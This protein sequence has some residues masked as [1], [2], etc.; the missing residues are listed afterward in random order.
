MYTDGSARGN[1]NGPGGYGTVIEFQKSDGELLVKELSQGYVKTTNNR[2]ELMGVIAGFEALTRPCEIQL[3]SDSQYVVKAFQD[4]WIDG[5][6]K[7]GWKN[8]SGKALKNI[9]L[10]KALDDL[11]NI[12]KIKWI[13]VKGHADNVYNNRCDEL[14]RMETAKFM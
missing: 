6:Q 11:N 9:D 13:K 3:F 14:A 4:H 1:P 10:W 5:W 2:M 8:A 12:H 7:K